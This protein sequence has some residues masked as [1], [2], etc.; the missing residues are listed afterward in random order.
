LQPLPLAC[1]LLALRAQV[2]SGRGDWLGL[3]STADAVCEIQTGE[4]AH[5]LNLASACAKC[6]LALDAENSPSA[7]SADGEAVRRRC[8]DRGIAALSQAIDQGFRDGGRLE[9]DDEFKPLR[10]HPGY[11]RLIQRI[12]DHQSLPGQSE[13]SK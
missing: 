3:K 2:Q 9:S 11:E 1:R 6:A 13:R 10:T 12:K 4:E 7:S 8:A 5:L